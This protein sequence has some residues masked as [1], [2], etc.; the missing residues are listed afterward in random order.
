MLKP[1]HIAIMSKK[2]SILLDIMYPVWT[3]HNFSIRTHSAI[4]TVF[5]IILLKDIKKM[6]LKGDTTP[7]VGVGG[8]EYGL[9]LQC[10]ERAQLVWH[11]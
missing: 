11:F 8:T 9:T 5:T 7:I 3:N 10:T 6:A 1:L 4:N 2:T